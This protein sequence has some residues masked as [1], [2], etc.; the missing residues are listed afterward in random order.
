M[1]VNFATAVDFVPD[2]NENKS[3]PED[4]QIKMRLTPL[5][6]GESL[7]LMATLQSQV[8]EATAVVEAKK[9]SLEQNLALVKACGTYIPDHVAEISGNE[10]FSVADIV[11]WLAFLGL[12]AETLFKLIEISQPTEADVKNSKPQPA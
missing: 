12:A 4:K 11:K 10:D 2:W 1:K 9:L 6:V 7:H 8:G 3:L 5:E